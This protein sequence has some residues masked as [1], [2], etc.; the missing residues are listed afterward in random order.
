[1]EQPNL[2]KNQK[3]TSNWSHYNS[4]KAQSVGYQ[5]QD[6]GPVVVLPIFLKRYVKYIL[7]SN[8]WPCMS[9]I[10]KQVKSVLVSLSI[11]RSSLWMMRDVR[12]LVH[13]VRL[14]QFLPH[15]F[16][17]SHICSF[18]MQSSSVELSTYISTT[19]ILFST[20]GDLRNSNT[21]LAQYWLLKEKF[22][23]VKVRNTQ[24]EKIIGGNQVAKQ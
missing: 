1:M 21:V 10:L 7:I 16:G 24:T 9:L 13:I 18:S 23:E 20:R 5:I 3:K 15:W 11:Q 4:L 19:Y 2:R 17:T 6:W 22:W 14:W 12:V 8:C